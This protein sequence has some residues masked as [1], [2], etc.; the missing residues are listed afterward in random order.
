MSTRDNF[1]C[2]HV[3]FEIFKYVYKTIPCIKSGDTAIYDPTSICSLVG[4]SYFI[5]YII[6]VRGFPLNGIFGPCACLLAGG[7]GAW[8]L[9]A[10][11]RRASASFCA[12]ASWGW[13]T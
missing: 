3:C 13:G 5:P 6:R 12:G 9:L 10:R 1:K 8:R 11:R 7:C 2:Q 4:G